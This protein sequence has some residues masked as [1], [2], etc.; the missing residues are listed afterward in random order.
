MHF[1]F[2]LWRD[3]MQKQV[4]AEDTV[5]SLTMYPLLLTRKTRFRKIY[6]VMC[7]VR[8]YLRQVETNYLSLSLIS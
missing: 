4:V 5:Q 6:S 7:D 2:Q 1:Y 8:S 3:L